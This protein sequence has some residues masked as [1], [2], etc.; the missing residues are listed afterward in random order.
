[1]PWRPRTAPRPWRREPALRV[2]LVGVKKDDGVE[3]VPPGD[4]VGV[5]MSAP[6]VA[7]VMSRLLRGVDMRD[8]GPASAIRRSTSG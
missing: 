5:A 8:D 7:A 3:A 6:D 1:M 4:D 2:V